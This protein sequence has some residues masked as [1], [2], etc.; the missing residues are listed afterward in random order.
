M[1][2]PLRALRRGPWRSVLEFGCGS[3]PITTTLCEFLPPRGDA[4]VW[5]S[6]IETVPFHFA[7]HKLAA[8]PNVHAVPLR[9]ENRF[10]FPLAQKFDA[11]FCMTVLEHL[12]EPL[13]VVEHLRELL[14]RGGLLFFDYIKSDATGLDTRAGRDE[15]P[16]VIAYLRKHFRVL[17]GE[18]DEHR[19]IEL[20]IVTPH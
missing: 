18:L 20:T 9:P 5:I 12:Q 3:A 2:G 1:V 15:R 16:D 8:F 17:Q 10:R 7:A 14:A 6:D 11:I 19:S 13:A 4:H